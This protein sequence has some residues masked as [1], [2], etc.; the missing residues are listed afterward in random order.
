M[1]PPMITG[2]DVMFWICAPLTVLGALGL[3]WFRKAV[4]AMLSMA[5]TM[6]LLAGLYASLNAPFLFV[7]QIIVYTGAILMLFLFVMMLVGIDTPDSLVE[8]IRGQ[9][10]WAIVG[11][12]GL[13]GLLITG[14][15]YAAITSVGLEAANSAHGGN[16]Q[17]IA[18]LLFGRY[19]FAFEVTSALLITAAVGAMMLAHIPRLK[20]KAG[21]PE[22]AIARMK[23]YAQFGLHP[24]PK[25]GSGV[26]AT[27][28]SIA[29]PSLLPD[30]SVAPESVS[31]VLADRGA[32]LNAEELGRATARNYA[33]IEAV[34]DEENGA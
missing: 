13:A 21:Q 10:V 19:V 25:P 16:V 20:P 7:V 14:V 18:N 29:T 24:G 8:T 11:G 31:K 23:A 34:L 6:I 4:Y 33:A 12:V 3:V 32:I 2:T 17:G 26:F 22:H 1:M 15:G 27:S 30:G 5:A 9:R 28:N